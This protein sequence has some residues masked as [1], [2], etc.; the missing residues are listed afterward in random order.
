MEITPSIRRIGPGLVNSYLVGE[1]GA[2]TIVDA[3]LPGQWRELLAELAAIG[4]SL[5]DVRAVL[6]THAHPDHI[7]FAERLRR[8]CGVPICVHELDAAMARGEVKNA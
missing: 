8:E 4:R 6:L 2:G 5:A 7:G 3:G 1:G